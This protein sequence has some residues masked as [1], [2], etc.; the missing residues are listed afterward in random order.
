MRDASFDKNCT[1]CPRYVTFF[2]KLRIKYP[3]YY[4]LP[5]PPFGTKNPDLVIVGLAPGMH[6]ANATGRPFTG[7]MREFYCTRHFINL[8]LVIKRGQ[9]M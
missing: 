6:G 9:A 8:D 2:Q 7:I 5:V 3:D 4:N 1:Q